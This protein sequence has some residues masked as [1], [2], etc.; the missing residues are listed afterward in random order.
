MKINS[1]LLLIFLLPFGLNLKAQ[2]LKNE[3]GETITL[4]KAIQLTLVNQPV[5]KQA[6]E[7]IKLTAANIH[8]QDSYNYPVVSANVTDHI[9]GPIPKIS[10]GPGSFQLAP[11]NNFDANVSVGYLLYDFNRRDAV[12]DVL[13]SYKLTAEE[14]VNLVKNELSYKTVQVFYSILFLQKSEQVKIDQIDVLKKHIEDAQKRV[15]SGVAIDLDVLTTKVRVASA[16]N[17]LIDI[18]KN[19]D[20][21]KIALRILLGLIPGSKLNLIGDFLSQANDMQESDIV[22]IAF[23]NREE[24]KIAEMSVNSNNLQRKTAELSEM[25]TVSLMGQYG[26]KNGYVPN[27]DAYRGNWVLGA[28]VSVPIFNGNKKAALIESADAKIKAANDNIESL[29]RKIKL[30]VEQSVVE[31]KS[32]EDKLS[33]ISLQID[34]AKQALDKAQIQYENGVVKNLELLDAETSLTETKLLY[35]AA[36]Y[37]VTINKY[38]VKQ[39][40]G[41]KIW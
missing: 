21:S 5:I 4:E 24:I 29:K 10:I 26:L 32:S 28:Q 18:R 39:A 6:E 30:E 19:L 33:S 16:E 9:I 3:P 13:K 8:Q 34:Q 35:A 23:D 12:M 40:A 31:L 7:E 25:P 15:D 2:N 20:K 14:K 17:Q 22:Q 11:R 37:Q 38:A 41:E 36:L 27:L 1:I